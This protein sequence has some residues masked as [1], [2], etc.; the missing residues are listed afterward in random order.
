MQFSSRFKQLCKE[1]GVTQKQA[2]ADMGLHRNAAQ[3]WSDCTPQAEAL[4]TL[5]EYFGITTDELL[6]VKSKKTPTPE[7]ERSISD[8][9]L[10]FALWGD[11]KDMS[12]DDLADVLRY[13]AFVRERKKGHK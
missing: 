8:E 2:L 13:A 9:D 1:R 10:K 12:D 7:G 4:L 6:G 5:S 3:R 11:C